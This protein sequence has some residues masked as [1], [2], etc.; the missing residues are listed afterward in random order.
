MVTMLV[1][2]ARLGT[3]YLV[4]VFGLLGDVCICLLCALSSVDS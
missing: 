1:L 3:G 4:S 2:F